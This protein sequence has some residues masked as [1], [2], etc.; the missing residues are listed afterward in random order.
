M[1]SKI[2]TEANI[3]ARGSHGHPVVADT[4]CYFA[5]S[6]CDVFINMEAK[7]A[8]Y[9]AQKAKAKRLEESP[10]NKLKSFLLN[11]FRPGKSKPEVQ[12]R[13]NIKDETSFSLTQR[14]IIPSTNGM[15]KEEKTDIMN[16]TVHQKQT[17]KT[18]DWILLITKTLLWI[19]LWALFIE[20]QFGAVY[21]TVSLLLFICFSTRTGPK[22]DKLSA[23]SVFNENCERIHGTVTAEQLQKNMF[24]VPGL[25]S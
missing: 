24:G 23:Y 1:E 3:K 8:E 6:Q 16:E 18:S 25:Q 13:E 20:L 12:I 19:I 10:L 5:E 17:K 21:F 9:R 4:K 22:D 2:T 14:K 7:L 15:K 11:I